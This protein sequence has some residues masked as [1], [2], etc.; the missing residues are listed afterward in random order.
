MNLTKKNTLLASAILTGGMQLAGT[1]WATE[2]QIA[3]DAFI[4]TADAARANQNFGNGITLEVGN[5]SASYIQIDLST[6][7]PGTTG[8]HVASASLLVWVNSVSTAGGMDVFEVTSPWA[9]NSIS[10]NNQPQ[11]GTSPLGVVSVNAAGR[12]IVIDLTTLVQR[13]IDSPGQNHGVVLLPSGVQPAQALFDSKEAPFGHSAKL[14]ISLYTV[15]SD[16]SFGATGATG[17]TG[18]AG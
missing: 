11:R 14:D 15:K 12:Y 2:G 4:S 9:E 17:A 8:E 18:A 3:A 1:A 7:P 10:G 16:G 13:W 6:L 5:S